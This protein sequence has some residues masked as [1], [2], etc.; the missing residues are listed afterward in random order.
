MMDLVGVEPNPGPKKGKKLATRAMGQK[1]TAMVMFTAPSSAKKSKKK[2]VST[3]VL[4]QRMSSLISS[5]SMSDTAK[6]RAVLLNPFDCM[7]VR[8]GGENMQP[9]GIATLSVRG[10]QT[11]TTNCSIVVYPWAQNSYMISNTAG[12]GP[13]TYALL[14]AF[15]FPGGASLANIAAEARVIAAGIR[16]ISIDN[17][18][19]NQGVLTIGCLPRNQAATGGAN[20]DADGIPFSSSTTATQ[21]YSQFYNYLQTESYP[22]REGASAVYRPQ[23]PLD[24]TFRDVPVLS[25]STVVPGNDLVPPF[26]VGVAGGSATGS[27]LIEIIAH[28]E[29][30]VSSGAIG[31]IG[32]GDS[33][34]SSQGIVDVV[35]TSFRDM[36]DTTFS[37]VRG[38]LLNAA[39]QVASGVAKAGTAALLGYTATNAQR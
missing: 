29:Y 6:Y 9:T 2:K 8:M 22:L 36:V 13:Y 19:N 5:G 10:I 31:V 14:S 28:I 39:T 15:N 16:V 3:D 37:G 38:G 21:G 17:A 24:F 26:V 20:N 18:N 35:K 33:S 11:Y 34:I 23:D 30:T 25:T 7:P 1:N 12:S 32:T 4:S 27:L